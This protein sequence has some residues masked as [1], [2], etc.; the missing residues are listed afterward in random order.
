MPRHLEPIIVRPRGSRPG[1]WR[2]WLRPEC[3]L[4][5]EVCAAWTERSLRTAP[6]AFLARTKWP[7][8]QVAAD[9]VG[10][11]LVE[12]LRG[13]GPEVLPQGPT[14]ADYAA[15][16][17]DVATSPRAKRLAS[18]GRAYSPETLENYRDRIDRYVVP[19]AALARLRMGE[20]RRADLEAFFSRVHERAGASRTL[21]D[22]WQILHMIFAQWCDDNARSSPFRGMAKPTYQELVRGALTEAELVAIF[23]HPWPSPLERGIC[24]L[25]FWEGLRRG[26]VF[27]L[28][29]R[30]VDLERGRIT[31]SR[32][33]KQIDRKARSEGGT[34]GRKA[35][36]LPLVAEARAALEAL[37]RIDEYVLSFPGGYRLGE[38]GK[39]VYRPN[40]QDWYTAMHGAMD[41]AGID[42][43]GRD[44]TPHSA[45]HSI[46]SVMLARGVPKE[47]I[48]AILGHFDERTTDGYL[49]IA[50]EEID[51]AGRGI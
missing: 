24:A 33:V 44:I 11:A 16:F 13:A 31:V 17:R 4:P 10:Q 42:R 25:A 29:W 2:V 39:K 6:P 22:V 14:V 32:A 50:A 47:V 49:H 36:I 51:K 45:R 40:K 12:Y 37:P 19:D 5:P 18:S 8:T 27:A 35:R 43:A 26:E 34:K 28:R 9:R 48:K 21:Q 46:A 1:S 7:R 41:R 30:D 3:G 20:I 38:N 23:A 15:L